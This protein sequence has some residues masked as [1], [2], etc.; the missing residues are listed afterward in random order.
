M[1]PREHDYSL[2]RCPESDCIWGSLDGG[3]PKNIRG[4]SP[5]LSSQGWVGH[6]LGLHTGS[7]PLSCYFLV[8]NS[9]QSEKSKF[10][11]NLLGCY[12]DFKAR[13]FKCL[14]N[15]LARS[16]TLKYLGIRMLTSICIFALDTL[17]CQ[18]AD[19]I[20]EKCHCEAHITKCFSI[21]IVFLTALGNKCK[22]SLT[23]QLTIF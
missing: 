12:E 5:P 2:P 14:N 11:P 19:L 4:S 8:W 20:W 13:G 7:P 17:I 21:W 1:L 22:M 18:K 9:Q 23:F 16:I 15:L 3:Y 10:K 6:S